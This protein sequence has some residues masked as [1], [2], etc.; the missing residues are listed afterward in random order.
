[1]ARLFGTDG[2]RGIAGEQLTAQLAM[3]IGIGTA[4]VLTKD[5]NDVKIIIGNDGRKSADMLVSAIIS[6]LTSVG[7][8][9]IDVGLVPTP[10]ISYLVKYYKLD[11][12][13]MVTASH[14]SYEYNGI[15]IFDG[16]GYK[17][18]DELEDEIEEYTVNNEKIESTKIGKIIKY[19]NVI[20]KYVEHL[21]TASKSNMSKL[22]IAVDT[23]NGATSNVIEELLSKLGIKYDL[24][25]NNPDGK[26]INKDCGA[27]HTDKLSKYVVENKLDGGVAFDGD[28]DRAIFV[29]EKGNEIDG[30]YVLAMLSLELRKDN[31]LNNNTIVGTIMSNLGLIKF[32]E[33]NDINFIATKV[34]DRYVLEEINTNNLSLGGEQSGHIIIRKYACTGDGILT[35]I[36]VFNIL[37]SSNKKLSEIASVMKKYPQ[38]IENVKVNVDKKNEFYTNDEIKK[39]IEIINEKLKNRGRIVVRPS[40]T[41][42]LIRIMIEGEDTK[43]IDN[44][45]KGLA[46]V[47]ERILN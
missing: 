7:V 36:N 12:G 32:C 43:E 47:I 11:A 1:M 4:S 45:A 27:L 5:R 6:G 37:A 13:I 25:N 29:D 28:G 22:H 3:N 23:A 46:L 15:K 44:L 10:A 24:I 16:N 19:D 21:M 26:N 8:D 40:G 20:E 35:M 30:D 2:V 18:A 42:P 9:V 14:N 38:V 41:E 34:G 33:D 39:N 17:L 31:E